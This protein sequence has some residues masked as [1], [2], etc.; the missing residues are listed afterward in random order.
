MRWVLAAIAAGAL[1]CGGVANTDAADASDG[2]MGGDDA[3]DALVDNGS[4]DDSSFSVDSGFGGGRAVLCPASEPSV[5]AACDTR[6]NLCEY[7]S[8]TNVLCNKLY[9]CFQAQWVLLQGT[10]R[11][12]VVESCPATLDAGRCTSSHARCEYPDAGV[13]CVCS[14][15]GAGPGGSARQ[16]QCFDPGP[17]CALARPNIGTACAIADGGKCRY[18]P[19]PCCT[20]VAL[21]C[22]AGVWDGYL[23]AECP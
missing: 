10:S 1:G 12:P 6:S 5:G 17:G 21:A 4:V 11:C 22:S 7:G 15:C 18:T 20:G 3:S 13:D 2:S 9:A 16:W 23:T 14:S 19:G 8:S